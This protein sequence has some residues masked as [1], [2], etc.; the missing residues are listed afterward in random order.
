V[1]TLILI[2]AAVVTVRCFYLYRYPM[3]P[4]RKCQ[5]RGVNRGSNSKRWGACPKCKGARQVKRA[6]ATAVHRFYWSVVGARLQERRKAQVKKAR[7][8]AG[9]PEL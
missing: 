4:C 6:G 3:G 1:I 2:A 7:E 8:K 9:Y 5:G